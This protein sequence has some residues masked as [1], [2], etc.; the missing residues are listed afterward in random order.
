MEKSSGLYSLV[1]D[2]YEARILF[3]YYR[4]EDRLPPIPD[5]CELFRVGRATVRAALSLLEE[6]GYIRTEE[7]RVARVC[8]QAGPGRLEQNAAEYFVPRREG[9][10]ELNDAGRLLLVPLWEA[11]AR[12]WDKKQWGALGHMFSQ[13]PAD[14]PPPSVTLYLLALEELDNRLILNLYWEVM[15]YIRVPALL[16]RGRFRDL[17]EGQSI[18]LAAEQGDAAS[19][20]GAAMKDT[21]FG[22]EEKLFAFIREAG[23]KYGLDPARQL[24]FRWNIYRQRPQLRYSLSSRIIRDIMQGKYPIGSYLPSFPELEQRYGVSLA[25]VRRT[26]DLLE[27][28]G[29]TRPLHGKGTRVCMEC[30]QPDF[31]KSEIQEGLRLCR[32]SLQLLALT[33]RGVSLHTLERVPEARRAE[34]AGYLRR[35]LE[36]DKSYCCFE[37]MLSFLRRESPQAMVRECY[38]ALSDLVAWGYPFMRLL[39]AEKLEDAYCTW[40]ERMVRQLQ[41]GDLH[42]F[43]GE[44]AAL[45]AQ[46]EQ[47]YAGLLQRGAR[48]TLSQNRGIT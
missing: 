1:Y 5:I 38:R 31:S 41:Q 35:S 10:L 45:M 39:S 40:V 30:A 8:Y 2:F 4:N 24:P 16:D 32:E 9:L 43:S 23:P 19:Y 15:R 21:Y 12:G 11:G 14:G 17:I 27:E 7:R 20:L 37:I 46:E 28:L 18:L 13:N 22:L 48:E 42:A 36:V 34:L 47:K 25:T 3:G 6:S 33:I 29:V 44:W 26:L